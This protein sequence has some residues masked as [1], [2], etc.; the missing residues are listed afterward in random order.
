MEDFPADTPRVFHVETTW[1]KSFPRRFNVEYTRCV[2]RFE[3]S[4]PTVTI[5]NNIVV[6]QQLFSDHHH[7]IHFKKAL[8]EKCPN[9]VFSGRH[10]P[11]FSP[12]TGKYGLTEALYYLLKK[13]NRNFSMFCYP[14]TSDRSE[15]TDDYFF[16]TRFKLLFCTI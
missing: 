4:Y 13:L 7:S 1:K 14:S 2:C 9:S 3:V 5:T 12:N 15:V 6:I 10:F 11:V 16:E 8:R